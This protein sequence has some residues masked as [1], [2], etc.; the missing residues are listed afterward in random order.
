MKYL[1]LIRHAKSS[2][3][4]PELSDHDRPLSKRG[5]RDAPLMAKVLKKKNIR[6]DLILSSTAKRAIDLAY[7]IAEELNYKKKKILASKS[8]Y[9]ADIDE[10]L[11]AVRDAD[12]EAEIVFMLGHNPGITEFAN[13]LCNYDIDNIPTSG[14]FCVEFEVRKWKEIELGKGIF[15]SFDYPKKYLSE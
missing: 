7:I 11:S 14:I 8:L 5:K 12:D 2:W 3:D 10:M 4:H 9:L 13:S 15:K 1:Y 6:P